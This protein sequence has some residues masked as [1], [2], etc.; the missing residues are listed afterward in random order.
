MES[1]ERISSLFTGSRRRAASFWHAVATQ[2]SWVIR[3]A[4]G[5]FLLIVAVPIALLLCVALLAAAVVLTVLV[6]VNQAWARLRGVFTSGDAEG[7]KNVR[8]VGRHEE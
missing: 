3:V 7:R 8:V 4:L 2:P 6:A 1:T 5:A